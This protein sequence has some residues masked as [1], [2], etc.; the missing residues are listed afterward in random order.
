V[1]RKIE[2]EPNRES[3]STKAVY[4]LAIG[5]GTALMLIGLTCILKWPEAVGE[6]F[7][8]TSSG[9]DQIEFTEISGGRSGAETSSGDA[10]TEDR[11]FFN[12]ARQISNEGLV[13]AL[14]SKNIGGL[15][16]PRGLNPTL[17]QFSDVEYVFAEKQI[18]L[19]QMCDELRAL[20][21]RIV[22]EKFERGEFELRRQFATPVTPF[23]VDET[24]AVR[25]NA[26]GIQ[27]RTIREGPGY[28]MV[29]T[30]L[31]GEY[32]EVDTCRADIVSASKT[33]ASEIREFLI[34]TQ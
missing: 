27:C 13:K 15:F 31:V 32:V 19:T 4:W 33:L 5:C 14:N 10:E 2:S 12:V 34:A 8:E 20:Q 16:V 3:R 30:I 18:L 1:L 22:S 29:A 11:F 28:S 9:Y 6:S 24:S 25:D 23:T 17:A 21:K 26:S 7:R